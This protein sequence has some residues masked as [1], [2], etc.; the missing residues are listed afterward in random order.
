M[1][2]KIR[3]PAG[4]D[5]AA[6][7]DRL[8]SN[9]CDGAIKLYT[10]SASL[11]LRK[12]Q[13]ALFAQGSYTALTATGSRA[14]HIV[15]FARSLGRK[16]VIALAGRF[17][18]RMLHAHPAPTGDVWGDTAVMLPRKIKQASF[19]DVLTGQKISIEQREDGAAIPLAQA[20]AHCPA[21]LLETE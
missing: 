8:V 11:R 13:R 17:F 3:V 19:R 1:F 6:L 2:G 18:L 4:Q 12:E 9:P 21:A 16:T 5:R 15:G 7:M 14:N 10:T 20:F